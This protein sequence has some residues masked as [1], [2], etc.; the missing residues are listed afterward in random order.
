MDG[1]QIWQATSLT[2]IT[3]VPRAIAAIVLLWLGWK[4]IGMFSKRMQAWG[5]K[6]NWDVSLNAFLNLVASIFF[7]I[8]LVITVAGMIG[9]ETTSFIAMFGATALAIGLALQGSIGNFAGGMLLLFFRP[10]KVGDLI[11]AQG[12]TG[13]VREVKLFYT[14]LLTPDARTIFIPNGPLSAGNMINLS[15]EKLRRVDWV[16]S[17]SY[18]SNITS[19]KT[20]IGEVLHSDPRIS[21]VPEVFIKVG[22]LAESCINYTVRAWVDHSDYWPVH[23]DILEKVKIKFDEMAIS[24]PYPQQDVHIYNSTQQVGATYD[25]FRSHR[26]SSDSASIEHGQI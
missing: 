9:I 2:L 20:A 15:S 13:V 10:F 25:T 6:R 1:A 19:V 16:F 18:N 12:H 8:A 24:I 4:F 14:I 3:Y 23:F 5:E 17:A 11:E 7:K 21:T 22:Q 26:D